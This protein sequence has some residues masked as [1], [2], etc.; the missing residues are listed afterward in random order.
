MKSLLFLIFFYL[1]FFLYS[2]EPTKEETVKF[3]ISKLQINL[4]DCGT[5]NMGYDNSSSPGPRYFEFDDLHCWLTIGRK[6]DYPDY[7]NKNI[8]NHWH[9]KFVLEISKIMDIQIIDHDSYLELKFAFKNK[10]IIQVQYK[11]NMVD[12]SSNDETFKMTF[13][14]DRATLERIQKAFRHL[15]NICG[16]PLLD[17][18]LF[19]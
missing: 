14:N 1:P 12:E 9:S 7:N 19:K 17:D 4:H 5:A 15:C 6:W 13:D 10:S 11:N 3:L 16:N 8:I 2:Q 18:S